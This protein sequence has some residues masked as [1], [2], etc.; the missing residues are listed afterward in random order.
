MS[1][2]RIIGLMSGT[3]LDGLDVVDTLLTKSDS[4]RWNCEI[5]HA[6]TFGY[7]ADLMNRLSSC[8]EDSAIG[9]T[10]LSHDLGVYFGQRVNDFITEFDI[11]K[12]SVDAISSHGH[13]VFH[14]PELGITLQIGNGPELA[15][16]CGIKTVCDFRVMDVQL[17]GNGAPLVPVGDQLLFSDLADSF[18]NLGGFSNISF[19]KNGK[20]TAFDICPVNV[21]LNQL[22]KQEGLEYDAFGNLG[23]KGVIDLAVLKKLNE[24]S[25]YKKE[26]PKSLGV[27]WVS[28][29]ITP[30]INEDCDLMATYYEHIAIQLSIVLN[31]NNLDSVLI[32]GGGAKNS[33]LIERLKKHYSGAVIIPDER[34]V[35][36]KEAV[37]FALL[38]ALRLNN[39]INVWSSVTGARQ[40][41]ISGV[42]HNPSW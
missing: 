16:T 3:S 34:M 23:R 41:S 28:S 18:L 42:I 31:E 38:G 19:S 37:V 2:F 10:K 25:Y 14:Q 24:L 35:D 17:G 1:S 13:T 40:D 4:R 8:V 36:F 22:A 30:I 9:I 6:K 15:V 32:T 5:L 12:S 21:V 39:E 11:D 26:P 20:V 33:F 27:E 29:H 7:P